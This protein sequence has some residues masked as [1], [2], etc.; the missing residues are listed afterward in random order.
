MVACLS[1]QQAE[2]FHRDGFLLLEKALTDRQLHDLRVEVDR[3]VDESRGHDGPF[4]RMVDGRARFDVEPGHCADRPALRRVAS[5]TEISPAF[6][7]AMRA[8]R[9]LDATGEIFGTGIRFH[10]AKINSKLPG[11]ETKVRYH[12]DFLFD[13]HTN[14]D[15]MTVLFFLDDVTLENGPLEVVPGSHRG[16][17]HTLWHDGTF[18]GAVA[19]DVEAG[20]RE[21]AVPCTGPAGSAC[22]M[23]S[24][25]LHGSA[26]NRSELPRTLFIV[27]YA[28]ADA[29]P[30][31]P[32][33]VPSVHAGEMVLGQEPG[34]IRAV[35]F[36]M[37]LP[38]YPKT[39]SFFDQQAAQG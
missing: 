15:L 16:T 37:Q 38:D 8:N 31:V 13:P 1:P 6:D 39:A 17:L 35:P 10:H 24:R 22:L 23:H 36:E 21:K 3:W 28:A 11:A 30:L 5:P 2:A 26:A 29:V 20:C 4:G 27:A 7:A 12:Q 33:H 34:T 9:A 32:N 25:L 14:D 19:A 18:T